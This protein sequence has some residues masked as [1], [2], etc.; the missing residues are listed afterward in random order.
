MGGG[1]RSSYG[2]GGSRGCMRSCFNYLEKKGLIEQT[3]ETGEF[4]KRPRWL[5]P[6]SAPAKACLPEE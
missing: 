3:F 5:L 2:I 1:E 6:A 4:I